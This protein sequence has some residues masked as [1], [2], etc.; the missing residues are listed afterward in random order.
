[1]AWRAASP[2][3]VQACEPT[4]TSAIEIVLQT[5]VAIDDQNPGF[6]GA[7]GWGIPDALAAVL[8]ALE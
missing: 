4:E 3:L 8:A 2:P 1:M 6:E 5:A 7:L